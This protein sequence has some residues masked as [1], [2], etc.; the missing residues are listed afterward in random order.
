MFLRR[1]VRLG[2]SMF[3]DLI[4]KNLHF[5]YTKI[6]PG[7][8]IWRNRKENGTGC[9]KLLL[10]YVDDLLEVS[11]SPQSIMNDIGLTFDI[12][13]KKYGPPTAYL[14]AN[15][16]PFHMSD[17]KYAWIIKCYSC[18]AAAVQTIQD[19]FL[20]I[21]E[22]W[23]ASSALTKGHCHMDKIPRRT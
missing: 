11:H 21:I 2:K 17:G 6:Y 9:Y 20:R 5:K 16:E 14:G 4:E 8:H 3:K 10:I 12:K 22:S 19:F 1:Q 18:V 23:R 7:M 15:V 13:D